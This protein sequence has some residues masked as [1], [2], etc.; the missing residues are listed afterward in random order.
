MMAADQ[1]LLSEGGPVPVVK[2]AAWTGS[3]SHIF[4]AP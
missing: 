4:A 3:Y 2:P 1:L